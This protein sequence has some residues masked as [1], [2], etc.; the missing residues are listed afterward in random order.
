M[1]AEKFEIAISTP[2]DLSGAQGASQALQQVGAVSEEAAGHVDKHALSHKNLHKIIHSLNQAV[3]G[4][5]VLLQACFTPVGATVAIG[6]AALEH[7]RE[8]MKESNEELDKMEEADRKPL[9][10]KQ[11]LMRAAVVSNAVAME[12]L[13]QK[14]LAA[15]QGERTLAQTTQEAIDVSKRQAA[16]AQTHS[17]GMKGKEIAQLETLHSAKLLST[18]QYEAAK[19]A[20]EEAA[21]ARKM[22]LEERQEALE[23]AIKQ[24]AVERAKKDQEALTK[25]AESAEQKREE[26]AVVAEEKKANVPRSQSE[27]EAAKNELHEFEKKIGPKAAGDFSALGTSATDAQIRQAAERS[28]FGG[29]SSWDENNEQFKEWSRLQNVANNKRSLADSAPGYA[30]HAAVAEERSKAVADR[31]AKKAV[32]NATFV[33]EGQREITKKTGE[34]SDKHKAH[35]DE[36]NTQRQIDQTKYSTTFAETA[37]QN[38]NEMPMNV[39]RSQLE[40]QAKLAGHYGPLIQKQAEITQQEQIRYFEAV[41]GAISDINANFKKFREEMYGQ[42]NALRY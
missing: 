7:F 24:K 28:K 2:T 6:V 9:S 42:I 29:T 22:E 12:G 30:A 23:I 35:V 32:D 21:L 5:G 3:P 13:H 10:N 19:Y 34:L 39:L 40:Q 25:A 14:L 17:D 27:Y 38:G 26:L 20:I 11:E 18:M 4:L 15:A 8:K 36:F 1:N 41:H 33:E 16:D 37:S 31:T